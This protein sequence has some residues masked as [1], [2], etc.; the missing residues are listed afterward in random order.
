MRATDFLLVCAA[1]MTAVQVRQP[2]LQAEEEA[3][4]AARSPSVQHT[5]MHE[6]H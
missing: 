6:A 5:R 4:H 3:S 2:L 1:G